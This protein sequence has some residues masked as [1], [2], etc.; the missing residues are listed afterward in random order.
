MK[1]LEC[2]SKGDK[3]FSAFYAKV[4]VFGKIDSIESHY[5]SVKYKFDD[6]KYAKPCRKGERVDYLIINGKGLHARFLTP[7]YKL[8]WVKYLDNNPELVE[9]AK[10]FDSFNDMFKGRAINCQADVIREYVKQGREIIMNDPLV[11]EF[12]N[13]LKEDVDND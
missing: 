11:I 3:R 8:L 2:S 10:Q 5:Q 12:I 7:Y 4:S 6:K 9:Y 13:I 1:V